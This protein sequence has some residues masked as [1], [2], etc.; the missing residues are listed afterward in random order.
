MTFNKWRWISLLMSQRLLSHTSFTQI[1]IAR[2]KQSDVKSVCSGRLGLF[3]A[4]AFTVKLKT[5]LPWW[6]SDTNLTTLTSLNRSHL[7][8]KTHQSWVDGNGLTQ[9]AWQQCTVLQRHNGDFYFVKRASLTNTKEAIIHFIS[10]MTSAG[11]KYLQ[12]SPGHRGSRSGAGF[13][14]LW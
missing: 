4:H 7:L 11:C 13:D 12:Q 10:L 3:G 8:L 9:T 14:P 1:L 2:S 6:I 5:A